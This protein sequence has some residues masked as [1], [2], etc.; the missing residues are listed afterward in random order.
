MPVYLE[1]LAL[2]RVITAHSFWI[3]KTFIFLFCVLQSAKKIVGEVP[4]FSL[5][6]IMRN[7][8][9]RLRCSGALQSLSSLRAAPAALA[10][11]LSGA[12]GAAG[13]FVGRGE[14]R[15]GNGMELGFGAKVGYP[16]M[17]NVDITM[18]NHHV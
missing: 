6:K 5:M 3:V 2:A 14:E 8:W 1:F 10:A 12:V 17:V 16:K 7:H 13:R 11:A 4:I 18:E 15:Q 9:T